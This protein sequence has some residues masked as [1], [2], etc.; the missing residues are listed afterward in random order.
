MSA[1]LFLSLFQDRV[2]VGCRMAA[3]HTVLDLDWADCRL[4][5]RKNRPRSRLWLHH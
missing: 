2:V 1:T 5:S 3:R 4:A